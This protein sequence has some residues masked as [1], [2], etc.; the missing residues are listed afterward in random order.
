MPEDGCAHLLHPCE[1]GLYAPQVVLV[2]T[3]PR[4]PGDDLVA[5]FGHA[6]SSFAT[7]VFR[8]PRG[9]ALRAALAVIPQ[10]PSQKLGETSD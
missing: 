6:S 1:G 7:F 8:S 9:A 3:A 4:Q 2:S 5:C 10:G